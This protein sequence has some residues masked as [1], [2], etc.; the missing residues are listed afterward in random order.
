MQFDA[1]LDNQEAETAAGKL[2]NVSTAVKRLEEMLQILLR[3][4]NPLIANLKHGFVRLAL[5]AELNAAPGSRIL[6]PIRKQIVKDVAEQ[7]FI[8]ACSGADSFGRELN[9]ALVIGS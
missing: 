2:A 1:T 7:R 8:A 3:D 6:N 5:H 4:A 9:R